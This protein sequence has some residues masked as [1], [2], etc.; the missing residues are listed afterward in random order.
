[1]LPTHRKESQQAVES[2][3]E[4]GSGVNGV[5][6][7]PMDKI[8]ARFVDPEVICVAIFLGFEDSVGR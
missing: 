6:E 4:R 5:H 3:F 8:L 2:V 7:F 1:M